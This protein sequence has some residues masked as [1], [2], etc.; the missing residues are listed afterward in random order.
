LVFLLLSF[1]EDD[2]LTNDRVELA[3]EQLV[4][5]L[6]RILA[7]EV[8]IARVGGAQ[9]FNKH[10]LELN[11]AESEID[12]CTSICMQKETPQT[13]L[14]AGHVVCCDGFDERGEETEMN[15]EIDWKS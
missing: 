7:R 12:Q 9:Q 1:L 14:L 5:Q 8:R 6:G 15:H 13:H 2:V 10:C 3:E 11:Q 4:C